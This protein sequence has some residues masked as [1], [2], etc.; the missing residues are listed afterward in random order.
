VTRLNDP[1]RTHPHDRDLYTPIT[2]ELIAYLN[3]AHLEAGTWRN[4]CEAGGIR[5]RQLRRIRTASTL[6]VSMRLMDRIIVGSGV[7]SLD[8]WYWFTPEDL[9]R[10]GLWKEPLYVAGRKR[11]YKGKVWEHE[12]LSP[13]QREL[14]MRRKAARRRRLKVLKQRQAQRPDWKRIE[15]DRFLDGFFR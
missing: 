10:M 12:P 14:A 7:G 5:L 6:T 11:Y 15:R 2:D 9:I 13:Y 3:R 8:D 1:T 4:I